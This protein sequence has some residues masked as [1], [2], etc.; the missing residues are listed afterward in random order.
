MEEPRL[1]KI[2]LLVLTALFVASVV[3]LGYAFVF[4][5]N[6]EL[7]TATVFLSG[8]LLGARRGAFV[9]L[10]GETLYSLLNPFG[11][12]APPLLLAQVGAMGIAGFVGG[13]SRHRLGN[14]NS[15]W[16]SVVAFAFYGVSL[17]LLF[18]LLTT[19]SF[20]AVGGFTVTK[21]LA[22][23]A[24]GAPFYALHLASNAVIFALLVPAAMRVLTPVVG[25]STSH[26]PT[27]VPPA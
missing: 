5:P 9:G 23:L 22:S 27:P 3:A 20:F 8:V 6:I 17:T 12:A 15:W 24:F 1:S 14:G 19:L 2:R 11:V 13:T 16:P 26:H 21:F 25:Q 10:A 7:V 4:V 18:D